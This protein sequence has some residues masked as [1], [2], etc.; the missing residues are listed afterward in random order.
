MKEAWLLTY[1]MR[2]QPSEAYNLTPNEREFWLNSLLEQ[3][4][5]ENEEMKK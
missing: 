3:R 4:K 5:K 1:H 2:M